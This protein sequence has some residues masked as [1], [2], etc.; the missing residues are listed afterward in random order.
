[1]GDFELMWFTVGGACF[2]YEDLD[3]I[4][5]YY[6]LVGFLLVFLGEVHEQLII[7][8]I[9]HLFQSYRIGS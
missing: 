3:S 2:V 9:R 4:E 7:M 1:M 6:F 5:G 8:D